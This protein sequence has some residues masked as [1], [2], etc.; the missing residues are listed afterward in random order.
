MGIALKNAGKI[1]KGVLPK[2]LVDTLISAYA[3]S[4]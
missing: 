4:R 2:K 1:E 3:T